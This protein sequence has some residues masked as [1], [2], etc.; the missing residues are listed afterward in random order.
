MNVTFSGMRQAIRPR[1]SMAIDAPR[2]E[3]VCRGL[4]LAS[5]GLLFLHDAATVGV[6]YTLR[7]SYGLMALACVLGVC[8][9]VRGWRSAPLGLRLAA[10]LLVAVYL[11]SGIVGANPVVSGQA[12][13]SHTRWIVYLLDL[14]LGLAS[15]GLLLGIFRDARR[16]RQLA[17]A[18]AVGGIVAAAYGV[19]QWLAQRYGLPLSNLNNAPNSEG[20][21]SGTR[22]QGVG[23]LGWERIRGTWVEPFY[24]GIY[25]AAILPL[26]TQ[27]PGVHRGGVHRRLAWV[28]VPL[29]LAALVLTDSSLA[30]TS[31]LM[32]SAL[33]GTLV[34][35]KAGRP[36]LAGA[37]G[38]GVAL[39]VVLCTLVIADPGVLSAVTARSDSQL[40]V[41]L[42]VRT[43]AWTQVNEAWARHPVLGYGPGA[44]SVEL[45]HRV[46]AQEVGSASF[47]PVV[48]LGSAQGIWAA[49]LIDAG[50]LGLLAWLVMFGAAFYYIG[51]AAM[52]IRS[53]MLWAAML[54]AV[55]AVLAG[56]VGG[57]RL[58]LHV[59]VLVAFALTASRWARREPKLSRPPGEA[60]A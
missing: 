21:T 48:V 15:L 29:V 38:A 51:S 24:F 33:V 32:G 1:G 3:A 41:T 34:W 19:Y 47:A 60:R 10:G 59:W 14:G 30:W 6:S 54:A 2:N 11:V 37:A 36:L 27:L 22:F 25:L 52:R 23:L 49:S 26:V 56:E 44:S 45:A 43:S 13:G 18:L 8:F 40:H 55:V 5:A 17:I 42:G 31:L 7:V 4:V 35:V 57:D 16:I 53:K 28:G 58:D 46:E 39:M 50:V 20:V 9:V 12:R